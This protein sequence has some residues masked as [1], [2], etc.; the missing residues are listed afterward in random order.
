MD[1]NKPFAILNALS[2][3]LDTL[4][5]ESDAHIDA[6]EILCNKILIEIDT[7]K[8]ASISEFVIMTKIQAKTYIRKAKVEIGK[9][10]NKITSRSDGNFIDVIKPA[11]AGLDIILT[12]EY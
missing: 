11:R 1:I 6:I 7:I 10:N 3:E 2:R 9:Y 12:L 4:T 8:I 5:I